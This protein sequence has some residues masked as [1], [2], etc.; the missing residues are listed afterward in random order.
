MTIDRD[1]AL[2]DILVCPRYENILRNV[3]GIRGC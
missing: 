2:A 3:Y 1:M